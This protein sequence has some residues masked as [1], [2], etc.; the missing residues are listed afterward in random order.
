MFNNLLKNNNKNMM[1]WGFKPSAVLLKI[2]CSIYYA[3]DYTV[4]TFYLLYQIRFLMS[5]TLQNMHYFRQM[6]FINL[7]HRWEHRTPWIFCSSVFVF[8]LFCFH[9]PVQFTLISAQLP[10]C[11]K[12]LKLRISN[13]NEIFSKH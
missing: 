9:F 5:R 2:R 7:K 3:Y 6:D 13:W 12:Y 10:G 11:S 4:I 1:E 8:I